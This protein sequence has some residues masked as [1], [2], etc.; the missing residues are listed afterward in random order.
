MSI[1]LLRVDERLIHGQVTV[2]WGSRLEPERYLVVDDDLADSEWEKEL[3]VLGAPAEVEVEFF[4]VD[5]ARRRLPEWFA[6]PERDVLLTGDLDTMVRLA[7]DGALE[8]HEV[9]LG[10]IHHAPHRTQVLPYLFLGPPERAQIRELV[11]EGV[12]VVA[13]DL[14]GSSRTSTATLLS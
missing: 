1:V 9:N 11:S 4:R 14:P 6:S 13:Q 12:R 3:M 7:R 2:G 10:G 8:G 5:E